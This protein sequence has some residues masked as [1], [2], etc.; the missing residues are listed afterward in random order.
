MPS[1]AVNDLHLA[2]SALLGGDLTLAVAKNG[3]ILFRSKSHGV[4]DMLAM[5]DELGRLTEG[6]SLAD[7]VVGRAAALLCVYSKVVSIW[8]EDERGRRSHPQGERYSL[9]VRDARSYNTE[10][11]EE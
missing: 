3:K 9:P 6:A 10:S 4:S 5:I 8:R 11:R 1:T 7:S 2:R